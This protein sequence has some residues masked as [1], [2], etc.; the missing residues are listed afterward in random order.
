MAMKS[1]L[2][3]GVCGTAFTTQTSNRGKR[4][5]YC[6]RACYLASFGTLDERFWRQVDLT[7]GCWTWTGILSR[8][9]GRFALQHGCLSYAHRWFWEQL[10]GPVPDGFE[11]DHTCRVRRCVRPDHLEPVPHAVNVARGTGPT[12][13]NRAKAVCQRGHPFV[14][15]NGRRQCATCNRERAKQYRRRRRAAS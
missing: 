2:T 14:L 9:Y 13:A 5:I 15:M 3:C 10:Y 11:L 12:A 4:T 8:G 6:T 7:E 1:E